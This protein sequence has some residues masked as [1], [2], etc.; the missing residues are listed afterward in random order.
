MDI[1]W[2]KCHYLADCRIEQFEFD[3]CSPEINYIKRSRSSQ[4][5][6]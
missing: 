3:I 4:E 2:E 5:I 1:A 6:K